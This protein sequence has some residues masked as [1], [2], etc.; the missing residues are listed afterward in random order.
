MAYEEAYEVGSVK[1]IP[2]EWPDVVQVEIYRKTV[3]RNGELV[4]VDFSYCIPR[5]PMGNGATCWA[6]PNHTVQMRDEDELLEQL[7]KELEKYRGKSGI[8]TAR[9]EFVKPDK[10]QYR[11]LVTSKNLSETDSARILEGLEEKLDS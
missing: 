5:F 8:K 11:E 2:G 6:A 1:S 7:H 10:I 4:E 3:E 9:F